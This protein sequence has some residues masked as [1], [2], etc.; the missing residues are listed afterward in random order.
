NSYT[1]DTGARRIYLSAGQVQ[2]VTNTEAPGAGQLMVLR[3]N[4]VKRITFKVPAGTY[5][6][7]TD[8][9]DKWERDFRIQTQPGKFRYIHQ[10]LGYLT[11][12]CMCVESPQCNWDPWF[13]TREFDPET[14]RKLLADHPELKK[15]GDATDGARRFKIFHFLV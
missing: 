9:D 15:K 5:A 1:V 8:W 2:D 4:V 7:Y 10:R 3:R 11:P 12:E 14:I 13:L 6:G